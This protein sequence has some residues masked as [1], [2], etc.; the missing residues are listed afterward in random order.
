M[1][2]N[3]TL[4]RRKGNQIKQKGVFRDAVRSSKKYL[5]HSFGLRW[6]S[7]I[8]I[9]P[10]PWSSRAWALPFLTLNAPSKATNEAIANVTRA[11]LTG[12]S[13]WSVWYAVGYVVE[14]WYL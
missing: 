6:V 13:K 4:E 1:G 8:L 3:E 11:A 2:V 12:F 5:V 10:V 14:T 7:M 9:V